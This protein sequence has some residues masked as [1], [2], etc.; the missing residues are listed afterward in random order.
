M[1]IFLPEAPGVGG[2]LE[3]FAPSSLGPYQVL[4][5]DCS[6]LFTP[7]HFRTRFRPLKIARKVLPSIGPQSFLRELQFCSLRRGFH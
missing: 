1:A 3:I 4:N 5:S 6:Y 7:P 2:G